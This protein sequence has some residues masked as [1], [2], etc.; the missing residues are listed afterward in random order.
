MSR[1]SRRIESPWPTSRIRIR[2]RGS[3]GLDESAP[4][5][6][7]VTTTAAVAVTATATRMVRLR[8]PASLIAERRRSA[9]QHRRPPASEA[10]ASAIAVQ[11]P[12]SAISNWARSGPSARATHPMY[13]AQRPPSAVSGSTGAAGICPSAPASMP[14]HIA[15][16]I[17]GRARRLA[18]IAV[19]ET[20]PKWWA[21]SGAVASVAARV[22]AAPS[23]SRR[24][25]DPPR[26]APST[27]AS[28][29]ATASSP[30]TAAKL[31]CQPTSPVARGSRA[32]VAAAAR[33]SAYH[34]ARGRPAR[35]ATRPAA[36]ITPAR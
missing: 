5:Q 18:G 13:P 33:S 12:G 30:A 22:I 31:S 2:S 32:S 25:P 8:P 19:S 24:L 27:S 3:L 20:V 36:P 9:A 26:W 15:G 7:S 1:G 11:I 4:G 28:G 10:I 29:P 35:A 16:A 14:S 17:A 34:R 6:A 23:A 21:A